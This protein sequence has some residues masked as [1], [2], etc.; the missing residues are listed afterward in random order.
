[1][2]DISRMVGYVQ[3]WTRDNEQHPAW[4]MRV[5]EGHGKKGEP[6]TY[7]NYTVKVSRDSGIDLSRFVKGDRV[8]VAGRLVT[9]VSEKL[10]QNGKPY[11]NLTIWASSVQIDDTYQSPAQAPVQAAIPSDWKQVDDDAP[12]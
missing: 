9:E 8:V 4:G 2:A 5:D 7:T 3:S 6:R 10:D 12:F 11:K 1:M